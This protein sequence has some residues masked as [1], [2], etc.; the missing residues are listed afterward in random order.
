MHKVNLLGSSRDLLDF[1][2]NKEAIVSE[3]DAFDRVLLTC[4]WPGLETSGTR[5]VSR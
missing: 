1:T 5:V 3:R 4:I 2:F